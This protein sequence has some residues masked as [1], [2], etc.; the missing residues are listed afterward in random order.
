VSEGVC[1]KVLCVVSQGGCTGHC[2]VEK[3]TLYIRYRFL[4]CIYYLY[5]SDIVNMIMLTLIITT[6]IMYFYVK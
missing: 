1:C 6:K 4:D 5:F 3:K 2:L